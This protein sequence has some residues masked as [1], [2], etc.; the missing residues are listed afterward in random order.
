[1]NKLTWIFALLMLTATG[2]TY[3]CPNSGNT[4]C[5][6]L[7]LLADAGSEEQMRYRESHEGDQQGPMTVR[8][9]TFDG[10]PSTPGM[11]YERPRRYL[12]DESL[13]HRS[14]TPAAPFD[15]H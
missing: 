6:T 8:V 3:A 14:L 15:R 11:W 1:M 13:P 7:T 2:G 5:V 12:E 4:E 10:S 9:T